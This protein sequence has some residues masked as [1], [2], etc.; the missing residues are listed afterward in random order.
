[1]KGM[2][3]EKLLVCRSLASEAHSLRS[4]FGWVTSYPEA[5]VFSTLFRKAPDTMPSIL[6]FLLYLAS[7][8]IMRTFWFVLL[9]VNLLANW[10]L[11]A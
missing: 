5:L 1:M 10:N 3:R 4:R 7:K 6:N 11:H 9:F 2:P 8:L